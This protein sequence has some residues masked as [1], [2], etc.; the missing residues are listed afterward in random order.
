MRAIASKA[1]AIRRDAEPVEPAPTGHLF[2]LTATMTLHD[3]SLGCQA[4]RD[5]C[6]IREMLIDITG[7]PLQSLC[8]SWESAPPSNR[9]SKVP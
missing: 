7:A 5:T 8:P 2:L 9:R 1:S 6:K 3:G 4:T